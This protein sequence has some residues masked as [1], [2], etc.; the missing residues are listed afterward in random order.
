MPLTPTKKI[1]MDGKMVA[2]E[3]AQVHVLTHT[4]H[5]GTG[6]FEGIR[7]YKT[8]SGPAIFRLREHMERLMRSCKILMINVPFTLEE[9]VDAC[10]EVV[11]VNDL[12]DGCY[13]RPL[14][15]LGYGEMGINPL[16]CPVNV[17]IAAWRS[18]SDPT[19]ASRSAPA[20]T[21]SSCATVWSSRHRPPKPVR[22]R[23]SPKAAW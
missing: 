22:S 16:N 17:A 14:V 21:S 23:E 18:C 11:R 19:R 5:Y 4:L 7:A 9:L 20:R 6:A 8:P 12:A 3:K 2:W 13:L 10:V 1:W 15:Y